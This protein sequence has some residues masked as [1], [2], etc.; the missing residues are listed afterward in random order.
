MPESEI[1]E[2]LDRLTAILSLAFAKE[3]SGARSEARAD[4]VTAMV[5]DSAEDWIAA[6]KLKQ[7][8]SRTVA[9]AEKTVQRRITELLE[10]SAL[11]AR[12]NGPTRQYKRTG[13]L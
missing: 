5:L 1:V 10:M 13:L 8:V 2:R 7:S 11:T 3:I 9:V 4:P 12:G 6:G